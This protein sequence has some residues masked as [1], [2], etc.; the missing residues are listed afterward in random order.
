[1]FLFRQNPFGDLGQ[2]YTSSGIVRFLSFAHFSDA[3]A[4]LH[5][6]WPENLF[7]KVYFMRP[8]FLFLPILAYSSLLFLKKS[9]RTIIFFGLLGLIGSFLAKGTNEPF[10]EIYIW[11]FE[12]VP[13]FVLFRDPTKFYLLVSLSYSV[14]IPF[15]LYSIGEWIRSKIK[16][17]SNSAGRQKLKTQSEYIFLLFII[18]YLLF[19]I[20]PAIMGQLGGTFQK[21][22]I[23]KE[24]IVL[25]DFLYGKSEFFRML[26]I[27]SGVRFN[28]FSNKHLVIA[29]ELLFGTKDIT[30]VFE[31]LHSTETKIYLQALGIKYIIVPFDYFGEIFVKNR[32]YDEEQ[33][34][35]TI[36]QL[37]TLP[38]LKRLHSFG[39]IVVFE[40]PHPKDRFWLLGNGKIS[41]TMINPVDYDLTI[42]TTEPQSLIFSENYHPSW[43]ATSD[44]FTADSK[45]NIFGLNSFSLSKR[46]SYSIKITFAQQKYY[47]YGQMISIVT[48]ISVVLAILVFQKK[49]T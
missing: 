32:K 8:E 28:Y 19:L 42:S 4:F 14:L 41:Y 47:K 12:H 34:K 1:M 45:K 5:P 29:S 2:S 18:L 33:Y 37:E 49:K 13:G 7:G 26:W 3:F 43:V 39:K 10:G 44:S 23:P 48:L 9:N 22:E 27:P 11:L 25:K 24:Y 31:K 16:D 35:D 6:N 17:P 38:W 15:S 21:H 30:K 20:N 36:E 46:G 40:V